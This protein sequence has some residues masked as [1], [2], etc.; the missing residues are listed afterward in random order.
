MLL[1]IN[2]YWFT[3]CNIFSDI[4]IP[5]NILLLVHILSLLL[6]VPKTLKKQFYPIHKNFRLRFQF[7]SKAIRGLQK[8]KCSLNHLMPK[9]ERCQQPI[10]NILV[11]AWHLQ[12]IPS[13]NTEAS[14]EHS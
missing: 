2:M 8:P 6:A 3:D 13:K 1:P 14:K 5:S 7:S 11:S 9:H 4:N 12:Q 10:L